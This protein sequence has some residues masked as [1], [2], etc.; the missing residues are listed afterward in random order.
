MK[1]RAYFCFFK[2]N[3]NYNKVDVLNAI[4]CILMSIGKKKG[5]PNLLY[6]FF[7]LEERKIKYHFFKKIKGIWFF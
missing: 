2:G 4:V 3:V 5:L 1:F 7:L 6:I